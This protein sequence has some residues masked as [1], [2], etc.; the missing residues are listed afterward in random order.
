MLPIILWG[1]KKISSKLADS[2][3]ALFQ[4]RSFEN[5]KV[6]IFLRDEA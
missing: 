2:I 3:Q 6:S 4:D 5:I 1:N